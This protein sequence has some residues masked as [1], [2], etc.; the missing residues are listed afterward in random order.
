M[1]TYFGDWRSAIILAAAED[2]TSLISFE[3]QKKQ[4]L[5]PNL[6]QQALQ[7]CREKFPKAHN[8]DRLINLLK[9]QF[10]DIFKQQC[11]FTLGSKANFSTVIKEKNMDEIFSPITDICTL[12]VMSGSDIVSW[13]SSKLL[14]SLKYSAQE[15]T[16]LIQ[17]DFYLPAPP[18][19]LPQMISK[20]EGKEDKSTRID[21][22]SCRSHVSNI[23]RSMLCMFHASKSTAFCASW[24]LKKLEHEFAASLDESL[25][26]SPFTKTMADVNILLTF[27]PSGNNVQEDGKLAS[28]PVHPSNEEM[29]DEVYLLYSAF[30]EVCAMLWMLHIRDQLSIS[31]RNYQK[32]R[33]E[34][35]EDR[36]TYDEHVFE[37]LKWLELIR[38]FQQYLFCEAEVQ[39]LVLCL[40]M[41]LPMNETLIRILASHF[42]DTKNLNNKVESRLNQVLQRLQSNEETAN[43]SDSGT[44]ATEDA[45][46]SLFNFYSNECNKINEE[47]FSIHQLFVVADQNKLDTLKSMSSTFIPF[48]TKDSETSSEKEFMKLGFVEKSTPDHLLKCL[49]DSY[50]FEKNEM[51]HDFIENLFSIILD[52]A[53]Q[54]LH[55]GYPKAHRSKKPAGRLLPLYY[56]LILTFRKEIAN[57]EIN[58]VLMAKQ[59]KNATVVPGHNTSVK[60]NHD[61][62]KVTRRLNFTDDSSATGHVQ[63]KDGHSVKDYYFFSDKD[64]VTSSTTLMQI[65]ELP[66]IDLNAIPGVIR[67]KLT[68]LNPYFEWLQYWKNQSVSKSKIQQGSM[69]VNITAEQ[70]LHGYLMAELRFG[71][72]KTKPVSS[73][74]STQTLTT[75][76]EVQSDQTKEQESAEVKQEMQISVNTKGK[77]QIFYV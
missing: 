30:R 67:K 44:L 36:I 11:S 22:V 37:C 46:N 58:N 28:Y 21:E 6:I 68:R 7:H 41:E 62:T 57:I 13:L 15:A 38:P 49:S 23:V 8:F 18:H 51:Y 40:A 39:D 5:A 16:L 50:S 76:T 9:S 33:E 34:G 65:P 4:S 66:V 3:N 77:C 35:N 29:Q 31:L 14:D 55:L 25:D 10:Y 63:Q 20:A 52:K 1:S 64:I 26:D 42:H 70:L 47:G 2:K 73:K 56:P 61:S 17:E 74:Q 59:F 24:Y 60:S 71:K 19:S 45:P 27:R 69:R 72:W 54:V 48:S 43:P 75:I 12:A 32:L 53:S